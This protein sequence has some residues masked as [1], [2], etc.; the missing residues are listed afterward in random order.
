[1]GIYFYLLLRPSLLE[2]KLILNFSEETVIHSGP[3]A[4]L[5][6]CCIHLVTPL[7]VTTNLF[8]SSISIYHSLMTA[9]YPFNAL[10]PLLP[11]HI[12]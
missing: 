6:H 12:L 2:P 10:K 11:T 4:Y 1:M 5:T 9:I 7:T 3:S 8:E